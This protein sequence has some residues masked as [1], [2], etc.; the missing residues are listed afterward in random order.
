[1]KQNPAFVKTL[2]SLAKQ[3]GIPEAEEEFF[4]KSL[5]IMY[6]DRYMI[7]KLNGIYG[8]VVQTIL[9]GQPNEEQESQ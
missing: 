4:E 1:M 3:Y 6:K 8:S 2:Q 7:T 5:N 9:N